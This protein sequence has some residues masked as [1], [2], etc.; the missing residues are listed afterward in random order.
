MSFVVFCSLNYIDF[1]ITYIFFHIFY[2]KEDS[3]TFSGNRICLF[4]PFRA[5]MNI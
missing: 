2:N 1:Q 4:L 3:V 5:I